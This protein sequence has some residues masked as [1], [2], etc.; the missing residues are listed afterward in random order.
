MKTL[1]ITE[2]AGNTGIFSIP[3]PLSLARI[4][5]MERASSHDHCNKRTFDQKK[6]FF[7]FVFENN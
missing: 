1:I 3:E 4:T 5:S 6:F 7:K 2:A